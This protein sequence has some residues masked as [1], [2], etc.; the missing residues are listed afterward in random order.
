MPKFNNYGEYWERRWNELGVPQAMDAVSQR[1]GVTS[2]ER[3]ALS[4]RAMIRDAERQGAVMRPAQMSALQADAQRI[5]PARAEALEEAYKA[6]QCPAMVKVAGELFHQQHRGDV[7]LSTKNGGNN[8]TLPDGRKV[9][10]DIFTIKPTDDL[11][12]VV[13]GNFMLVDCMYSGGSHETRPVWN[14]IGENQDGGRPWTAPPVPDGG[15]VEPSNTH[16]YDGGGNDTNECD[17]CKRSRFDPIHAIPESKVAHDYDGGEQD[18]GLCDICQKDRNDAIHQTKPDE[19]EKP[20]VDKHQFVGSANAKFCSECG[21]ARTAAVHQMNQPS[22]GGTVD[23][24]PVLAKLDQIIAGQEAQTAAINRLRTEV[25]KAVK[26]ALAI[27]PNIFDVL[28]PRTR[29]AKATKR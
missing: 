16:R 19:P 18:T 22:P 14:E 4:A 8:W 6:V 12:N 10:T 21:E 27:L 24:A 2:R 23:L 17:I 5:P 3:V 11:G 20:P 25:V 13:E 9:A 26:D 15:T 29:K 28:R 1:M 7:G